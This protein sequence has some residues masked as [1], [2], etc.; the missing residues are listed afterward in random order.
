MKPANI[1]LISALGAILFMLLGGV[2]LGQAP[3]R[4]YAYTF[5]NQIGDCTF[6]G[7]TFDQVWA[8]LIK[9]FIAQDVK[10]HG[11]WRGL[12]VIPNRPSGTL[13]GVWVGGASLLTPTVQRPMKSACELHF[14]VEQRPQGIGVYCGTAD[15]AEGDD[16]EIEKA[17]F[18]KVAEIL[19][20]RVEK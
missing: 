1:T 18:D 15:Y 10:G 8:A 20:G 14:L 19:Y 5:T 7:V 9:A 16:T 17:V 12:P 3:T 13:I 4:P 2:L 11:G 6:T